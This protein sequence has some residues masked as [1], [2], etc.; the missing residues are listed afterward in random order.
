MTK[1]DEIERG[2]KRADEDGDIAMEWAWDNG[3]LL[4]RAVRQWHARA[5]Y[6]E[7]MYLDNI[8][9]P[10]MDPDVLELLEDFAP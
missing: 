5:E 10:H 1:L 4:I 6:L 7:P 2:L 9:V 3:A 8:E